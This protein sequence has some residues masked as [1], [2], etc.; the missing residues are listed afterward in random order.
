MKMMRLRLART[1]VAFVC[2]AM[3][4]AAEA[5]AWVVGQ[6][7]PMSGAGATQG[8][9]YA[10]GMR[11]YFDQVNKAGGVQGQPVQLVTVD[12]VGHPEETVD[13]T[14]KLLDES[15]PVVLAG[16]FGNRNMAA[17]LDSK[18]LDQAQI[19]LVGYQSTDTRVLSAPQ[20]FSTRA[21]L[22]EEMAKI[23]SHLATVGITRLAL[24][25][26]ERPDAKA[27][28]ELVG[29]AIAPSKAKLV[30]S[31]ALSSGKGAMDKAVSQLQ[32]AQPSAQAILVVAS[33][34]VT[35]AFVEAY[36]MAGGTAQIYAT[37]E[38][39]IE[40]LAKRL[41][42]EFMSGL[43]I[44]QVVPSPYKV[45]MRLNKEFRDAATAAG[46]SL[47]VPVSYAMM[48]GY[49]NARVIVEAMRRSQPVS[50]EKLA[51]SLR[52]LDAVDLGGYWVSYRPGSQAGSKFVDLSIVNASGRVTQ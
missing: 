34:P 8:R 23:A 6:V 18:L 33:S 36:R 31:A 3:V 27:V 17:L 49:V 12:D 30:V 37:S 22:P 24:L 14:R 10:Q 42:V 19:S 9:A 16:Y 40:Q 2:G 13:K 1:A 39:D 44:A 11:L 5:N 25:H 15:K 52:G 21:N 4:L 32:K 28:T 43:S 51:A 29:K 48:E 26:D 41:P 38:A 47:T 46:K 7:A 35:S 20:V 45:T 50:R